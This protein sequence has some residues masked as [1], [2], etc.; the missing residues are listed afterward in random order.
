M[1]TLILDHNSPLPLYEQLAD[2]L[3]SK[4]KTG[5]IKENE[6]IEPEVD[7][8]DKLKVSRGTVRQALD[9]LVNEGLLKRIQGKGTFV[10]K[11]YT[12][13]T[14]QLIGVLVPYLQDPFVL[15]IIRGIESHLHQNGYGMLL[16]HSEGDPAIE[17]SQLKRM[18]DEQVLGIILFPI[19]ESNNTVHITEIIPENLPVVVLDRKLSTIKSDFVG[20]NNHQGAFDIVSYL[21]GKGHKRIC[22]VT[23]KSRPSSVNERIKGYEDAMKNSGLFPLVAIEVEHKPG[24]ETQSIPQYEDEELEIIRRIMSMDD[25]PTAIFCI[26]DFLAIGVIQFLK[27]NG[28]EIPDDVAVAGFDNIQSASLPFVELSTVQQARDEIG[29]QAARFILDRIGEE[30]PRKPEREVLI[31][32]QMIIR[33]ST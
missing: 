17:E 30:D 24:Q 20:A 21:L 2:V 5:E 15:D 10:T 4:I 18:R 1:D 32:T 26:N 6:K 23:T 7:I 11:A 33:K 19:D 12:S 29:G 28:Y 25:H 9:I 14:S 3:R 27:K 13:K 22:C 31:P 8:A 16:G